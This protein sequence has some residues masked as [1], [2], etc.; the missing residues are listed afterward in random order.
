[1]ER[2]NVIVPQIVNDDVARIGESISSTY[3]DDVH[4]YQQQQIVDCESGRENF[5][6]LS[7]NI[8]PMVVC[9]T[10]PTRCPL[11]RDTHAHSGT[12]FVCVYMQVIHI[13][14]CKRWKHMLLLIVFGMQ[15]NSTRWHKRQSTRAKQRQEYQQNLKWENPL[16]IK[17][18]HSKFG[19]WI[20]DFRVEARAHVFSWPVNVESFTVL[21]FHEFSYIP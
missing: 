18:E 14:L 20:R 11:E 2:E 7:I 3:T 13:Q 1:M 19:K 9:E 21:F 4:H 10:E 5:P 6:M 8:Q 16:E 17:L 15:A 12:P